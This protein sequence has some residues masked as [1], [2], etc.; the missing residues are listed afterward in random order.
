[1]IKVPNAETVCPAEP[2]SWNPRRKGFSL[3]E[4]IVVVVI[5]MIAAVMTVPLMSSGAGT[6]TLAAAQMVAADL[7]YA[8][9]M[10][11]TRGHVYRVTF[12]AGA[13][14]YQVEDPNGAVVLHPVNQGSSYIVELGGGRLDGVQISSV[15]FD[16]T[17][18]VRFDALG[19]PYNGHGT[20]L[21]SGVI[22][23]QAGSHSQTIHIEPVTGLITIDD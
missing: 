13:G 6:K 1:M 5:L 19:S 10:A 12:D 11:F 15:S 2:W 17:A 21:N 3:L 20:P 18:Q 16:G 14:R 23:L 9:S 22:T 7:E 4:I 8:R